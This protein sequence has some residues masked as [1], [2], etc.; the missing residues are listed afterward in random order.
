[1]TSL[2]DALATEQGWDT[3]VE[4][5][6]PQVRQFLEWSAACEALGDRSLRFRDRQDVPRLQSVLP[7]FDEAWWGSVVFSC[8]DSETSAR[9]AATRFQRPLPPPE[10]K[11]A[12]GEIEWRRPTV[13]HHR[14]QQGLTG[15][16]IA[17]LSANEHADDLREILLHPSHT[18][19]ERDEAI[20]RLG[21]RRWGRT[22]RFDLL[23]RSG[24]VGIGAHY[25]PTR[26]HL[27]G[28]TGPRAGFQKVWGT[29]VRRDNADA[30]EA[31]LAH[32]TAR[33]DDVASR[34]EVD[35]EGEPYRPADFENALCIFQEPPK[36]DLPDPG[37]F[38]PRERPPA[39]A[40]STSMLRKR[41][42][43]AGE[44]PPMA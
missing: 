42:V 37:A 34:A 14:K 35:W 39:P 41:T 16:K 19:E 6:L 21:L 22:T 43:D 10:A 32:W 29:E 3:L 8:F 33:W 28:S 30:C 25:E 5:R 44:R 2:Q 40:V 18:F 13:Q 15:A 26:A 23:A 12:V 24:Q 1:M 38:A 17:L 7:L 4:A 20:A 31:L 36:W 27:L 11:R 9:A